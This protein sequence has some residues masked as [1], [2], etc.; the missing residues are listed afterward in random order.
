[1]IKKWLISD[2]ILNIRMGMFMKK[3]RV[4]SR[5]SKL[6]IIQSQLIIDEIKK[7]NPDME[8]ELI[9]MKTTGDRILDKTLDKIGGKG[10][11]VKELDRALLDNEIDIAV[12]SLKDMPMELNDELEIIA[13]SKR[14]N[15]MDVLVLKKGEKELDRSRPIGCSSLRR[16]Q[17]L[18]QLYGDIEVKNI[19]G[20]VLTR[21]EKLDNGEYSALVLA[22]AG[23]ERLGLKD[24]ISYYFTED[25]MIPSA[26]QGILAVLG[27]K[28]ENYDF[29]KEIDDIDSRI[30]ATCEREFVK[31]LGGG[32]SSPIA[33]YAKTEA[34]RLKLMCMYENGE[35]N[36]FYGNIHEPKKLAYMAALNEKEE[37]RKK[38]KV[39]LC[40]AGPG[41]VELLTVKTL[42]LIRECDVIVYDRLIGDAIISMLPADTEKIYVGKNAGMHPV[43]QERINEILLEKAMDGKTV[44]RLKGGD[45]F[46]FGRGGEELELLQKN[47][48]PFEVV[49]GITS[50]VAVPAYNG[51]P[52][53]YRDYASAFHVITAHNKKNEPLNINFKALID[54]KATLIFLMGVSAIEEICNGLINAGIDRDMPACVLENG[55]MAKQRKV[56]STVSQLAKKAKEADIKS[57]SIIIVGR[58]C[59]CSERFEWYEKKPLSGCDIV[60]TR[61]V[62]VN[63]TLKQKL[64]NEGANVIELPSI[65]TEKISKNERLKEAIQNLPEY[66]WI[67]FTSQAGVNIFFDELII[68]QKDV[69]SLSKAKFACIGNTTAGALRN[70]GFIAEIIPKEFSGK[71]LGKTLAQTALADDKILI[72]RAGLGT[73][74]LINEL[75]KKCKFI[76]DIAIYDTLYQ[77]SII[78]LSQKYDEGKIDYTVFT[79]ASCVRGFVKAQRSTDMTKVLGVCIGNATAN[80]AKNN[81]IESL[82]SKEATL[83]SIVE[84]IKDD[85]KLKKKN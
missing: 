55:T 1:M 62:N 50:A 51:I 23:L 83:D 18:K 75:N 32:C 60:I 34:G 85:W 71:C 56:L 11:F 66:N 24:R 25:E 3:L 65:Y 30:C 28:G 44:V 74:D 73:E 76:D 40:G 19:R 7:N 61:P 52:V 72:P 48:I 39:Y 14:A 16:Q 38:G 67:V 21:L 27:R 15:P 20:N 31:K 37:K 54:T 10:L 53:T 47:D 57:P 9:T 69:R 22:A 35:K 46:V 49:S 63:G 33:G 58:V 41:D 13:F 5:E 2:E 82:I 80:E 68:A 78:D 81:N 79:S 36:T 59:E 29:L 8:I 45:P 70:R 12:H 17:Q 84:C 64:I 4:G 6:A 26:C 42:R 77:D 43:G